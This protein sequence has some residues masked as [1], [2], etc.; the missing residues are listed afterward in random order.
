MD[1]L[2]D[3]ALPEQLVVEGRVERHGDAVGRGDRPALARRPLDEDLVRGELVPRGPKAPATE[4][5]ELARRKRRAD[6]GE[7]LAEPRAE[8][9]QV[10]LHDAAPLRRARARPP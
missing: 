1:E 9:G 3:P 10:R 2:V 4:L 6:G 7:L 8:R 5:L